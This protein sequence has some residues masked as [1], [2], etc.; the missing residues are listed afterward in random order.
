MRR[1][2]LFSSPSAIAIA[3]ERLDAGSAP[4]AGD[5]RLR[6]D[7]F[8]L[9]P[10]WQARPRRRMSRVA[11]AVPM[12]ALAAAAALWLGRDHDDGAVRERLDAAGVVKPAT[13]AALVVHAAPARTDAG[14]AGR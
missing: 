10:V 9:V 14:T 13:T 7:G 8:E 11:A 5:P 3:T 12:L 2:L 1:L 6:S 4:A